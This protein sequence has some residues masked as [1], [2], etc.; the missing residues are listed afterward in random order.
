MSSPYVIELIDIWKSFPG[1]LALQGVSL[2]VRS[3]EVHA[4]VGENGAGKSTLLKI[5]S[6][7][8][9][10]DSGS[11]RMLDREISPTD[12]NHARRLGISFVHQELQQVP[13]L[14]V[15]ENIF[16]SR[17]R[18]YP[19]RIFVDRRRCS[20]ESQELL[21]QFSLTLDVRRPIKTFGIADRQMIEIA[22]A[23]L[24]DARLIAFDEPTSALSEAET[25]N[26]FRM[27]RELRNRGVGIIYVS[28]RLEEIKEIADRVTVL[29]DGRL[30]GELP[31]E[32]ANH[33]TI[34]KMM[35]GHEL[36]LELEDNQDGI[37][38]EKASSSFDKENLLD[39]KVE[40]L[41][42]VNLKNSFVHN[43]SFSLFRGEIL[44]VA[45]LVGSGRT[46][47]VRA[48]YGADKASAEIYVRGKR[49]RFHSPKDAIANG[50]GFLPEDRK[51]HGLLRLLSVKINIALASLKVMGRLGFL[52]SRDMTNPSRVLVNS[53]KIE[54]PFLDRLVMNLSGGNQQKVVLARWLLARSDILI[55]DEPT[56]GIDVGAKAEI[57]RLMDELKRQGKSII[58]VSSELP[59]IL[60]MSDRILIMRE[61]K[62]VRIIVREEAS[63][64][65][66][67][68]YATGGR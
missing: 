53:L 62:E 13:E 45:G 46:E 38:S 59:E 55:F 11:I 19:G 64:E 15:A 12:P 34:V 14:T 18:T 63:K 17:E 28:H 58:M 36:E 20:R 66:I 48:V 52:T 3:G 30:I 56:R 33:A 7:I 42:V 29:R 23:I 50:I 26:L 43:V 44:G 32:Q 21:S 10:K 67:M 4:L 51:L 1:V 40:V 5:V 68:F 27:I 54:P 60:R 49:V 2:R 16:L 47:L 8:I 22:K 61:G 9:Q 39:S 25:G 35:V 65:S 57:H 6:G 41:K 31:I 24:G 37:H